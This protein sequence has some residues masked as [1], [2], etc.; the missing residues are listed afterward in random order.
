MIIPGGL[1]SVLLLG[2]LILNR[3]CKN[4]LRRKFCQFQM[5]EIERKRGSGVTGNIVIK[6]TR[7]MLMCWTE[8]FINTVNSNMEI[9]ILS[10]IVPC[11]TKMGQNCF[12]PDK[13]PFDEWLSSLSTNSLYKSMV[14]AH[15]ATV[16]LI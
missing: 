6:I 8:D 16:L 11:L 13:K 12:S 14:A 9:D 1:T 2:D 15:T 3:P 4:F 7:E 5:A 10:T